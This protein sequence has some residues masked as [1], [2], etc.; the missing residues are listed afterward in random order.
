MHAAAHATLDTE[1]LISYTR[2]GLVDTIIPLQGPDGGIIAASEVYELHTRIHDILD[3]PI[4]F[5]YI[6]SILLPGSVVRTGLHSFPFFTAFTTLLL[7]ERLAFTVGST[8][9]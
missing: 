7:L 4:V 1:Y 2:A 8:S 9:P 3:S 6:F 5:K